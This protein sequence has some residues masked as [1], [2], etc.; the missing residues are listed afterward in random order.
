MQALSAKL[1]PKLYDLVNRLSVA[2]VSD[3]LVLMWMAID[4]LGIFEDL[5]ERH[6][7]VADIYGTSRAFVNSACP[8]DVRIE[9]FKAMDS[10]FAR[11]PGVSYLGCLEDVGDQNATSVLPSFRSSFRLNTLPTSSFEIFTVPRSYFEGSRP[12]YQQLDYTSYPTTISIAS[13]STSH[14]QRPT[15]TF[16]NLYKVP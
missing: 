9:V 2:N 1:I 6:R 7:L 11:S 15:A 14:F 12:L 10:V 16:F 13:S 4:N 3:S 5:Q 8:P